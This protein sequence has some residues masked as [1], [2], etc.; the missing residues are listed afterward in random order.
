[1]FAA[2]LADAARENIQRM[3]FLGSI[4][5]YNHHQ[6]LTYISP[7]LRFIPVFMIYFDRL[8]SWSQYNL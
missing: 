7:H 4:P 2:G 1:M 6:E 8:F 5:T 3:I